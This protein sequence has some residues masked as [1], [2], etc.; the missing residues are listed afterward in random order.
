MRPEWEA[1]RCHPFFASINWKKLENR[2]YD[3]KFMFNICKT[4]ITHILPAMF[5][6]CFG[7]AL[8]RPVDSGKRAIKRSHPQLQVFKRVLLEQEKYNVALGRVHVD[9]T[10]PAQV[11]DD[12][13]HGA[14][15][16]APGSKVL[17]GHVCDCDLPVDWHRM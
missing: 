15:C 3:R 13:L 5:K 1:L 11:A 8:L 9:Y 14:T 6:T 10:L 7:N 16:M 17:P 2:G 4:T 12:T